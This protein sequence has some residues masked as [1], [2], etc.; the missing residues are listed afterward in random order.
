VMMKLLPFFV[1]TAAGV[2]ISKQPSAFERDASM[3]HEA[4]EQMGKARTPTVASSEE[5]RT[6]A[7]RHLHAT[8]A[9]QIVQASDAAAPVK[10]EQA[11]HLAPEK[12][13]RLKKAAQQ[14]QDAVHSE[15]DNV[16]TAIAELGAGLD[17]KAVGSVKFS[18]PSPGEL[19][20]AAARSAEAAAET[21]RKK[22]AAEAAALAAKKRAAADAAAREAAAQAARKKA[23]AVA[24]E[25]AALAAKKKA[26]SA[27][28]AARKEAEAQAASKKA[29]AAA[30]A[31]R[32]KAAAAVVVGA[33]HLAE[34]KIT[35]REAIHQEFKEKMQNHS[36][37]MNKALED[38]KKEKEEEKKEKVRKAQEKVAEAEK[39]VQLRKRAEE[40][41]ARLKAG[42]SVSDIFP[43]KQERVVKQKTAEEEAAEAEATAA[44]DAA[45]KKVAEYRQEQKERRETEASSVSLPAE[46]AQL[47]AEEAEPSTPAPAATQ[48]RKSGAAL[49]GVSLAAVAGIALCVV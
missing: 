37:A 23:E 46:A 11:R 17:T 24:A 29:E 2:A 27:A 33:A 9:S 7:L 25:A 45:R 42:A 6:E 43:K 12:L 19:K 44:Q 39:E 34:K 14:M 49:Q 5:K 18:E 40:V 32:Q 35:E 1:A 22:A 10:Q 28:L 30:I 8:G 20:M 15:P 47:K 48:M 38:N 31:A 3:L 4:Q 16:R 36:V 13:K 41:A 21:T 26:E